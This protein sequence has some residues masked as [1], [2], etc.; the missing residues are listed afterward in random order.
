MQACTLEM[1]KPRKRTREALP[2]ELSPCTVI[3]VP[4]CTVW[5]SYPNI[6][7]LKIS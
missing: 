6:I 3:A 7:V 4:G 2:S 5:E 1:A